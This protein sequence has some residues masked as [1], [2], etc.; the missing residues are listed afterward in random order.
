MNE[1]SVVH[2]TVVFVVALVVATA[3]ALTLMG[4][5]RAGPTRL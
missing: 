2:S 4:P 3:A 5:G 1:G